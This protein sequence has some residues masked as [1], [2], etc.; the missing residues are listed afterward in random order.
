MTGIRKFL[1]DEGG[2][3]TI[4][5]V[6]LVP[7][8]LM[9]FFASF[10]SSMSMIRHVMLERGV[11]IVVRNI[12]LGIYSGM[13]HRE[14]KE[15]ICEQGLLA[16]PAATCR[17]SLR[18]WMQPINTATFAMVAPPRSCVDKSAPVDIN[19]DPGGAEFAFGTDNEI[20]LL[21][22]CLK[23]EPLFPTTIVG[24]RLIADETDGSYALVTTSVFVNEPG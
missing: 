7:V 16:G 8:I 6:L 5:F 18:I 19:F 3:A 11:D 2:T 4:E 17:A 22:I 13:T 24:A 14:L 23:A 10:E 21:R 1:A 9:I 20:M 15:K 12:R